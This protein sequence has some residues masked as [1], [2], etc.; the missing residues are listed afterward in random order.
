[1]SPKNHD[2]DTKLVS[3]LV[4]HKHPPS[5]QKRFFDTY[6]ADRWCVKKGMLALAPAS[7]PAPPPAPPPSASPPPHAV[8]SFMIS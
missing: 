5:D 7:P 4:P 1:M 6:E 3:H 8:I 2:L